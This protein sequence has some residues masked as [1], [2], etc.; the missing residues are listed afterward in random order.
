MRKWA[1]SLALIAAFA[2]ATRAFG[3]P[4][5]VAYVVVIAVAL[6]EGARFFGF[7]KLQVTR[8]LHPKA[9]FCGEAAEARVELA[10]LSHFPLAW[11]EVSEYLPSGLRAADGPERVVSMLPR[12][13]MRVTYPITGLKRGFY[14]LD[15]L[16]VAT[17]DV[18]GLGE[19]GRS[20]AGH[21]CLTVYPRVRPLGGFS[22]PTRLPFG[23]VRTRNR[24]FEDPSQVA[25]I[26]DYQPG[27]P[28]SR[29]HWKATA[30]NGRFEVK[31]YQPTV[32]LDMAVFLDVDPRN[33]PGVRWDR[34]GEMAIELAASLIYH[35]A[36]LGE[37]CALFSNGH[38]R[39]A[40]ESRPVHLPG[41]GGRRQVEKALS[42]L[43][44]L[45]MGPSA[46][47]TNLI[48]GAVSSLAWGATL[49]VIVP[50]DDPELVRLCLSLARQGYQPVILTVSHGIQH[51][52]LGGRA[53]L[54]GVTAYS[55]E[56]EVGGGEFQF[57]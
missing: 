7:R 10:N 39:L 57:S 17:G 12:E 13:R 48:T 53:G 20:F 46:P 21:E 9:V 33:Y 54:G 2:M 16:Y 29:I 55:V 19:Q 37:G 14:S 5:T 8:T 3:L 11:V 52:A 51:A 47:I 28:Q 32:A 40:G 25:G 30:R 6:A 43:A 38:D 34:D 31:E 56:M 45:E 24:V 42:V 27:D 35:L 50:V 26:R 36:G 15:A 44:R 1:G 4:Y 18:L 23:R 49:L 22:V 41:S